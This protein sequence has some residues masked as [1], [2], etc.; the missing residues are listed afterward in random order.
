M[1]IEKES[2]S[3]LNSENIQTFFKTII[4]IQEEKYATINKY[5]IMDL[6]WMEAANLGLIWL[7]LVYFFSSFYLINRKA[8]KICNSLT[9]RTGL[10]SEPH[11][12]RPPDHQRPPDIAW[13]GFTQA[14]RP[15]SFCRLSLCRVSV[16]RG[17]SSQSGPANCAKSM[18]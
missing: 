18:T 10:R 8:S 17:W 16:C 2:E 12:R 7:I 6:N 14:T 3:L 4:L 1:I 5:L 13:Y 9:G 15:H 11:G